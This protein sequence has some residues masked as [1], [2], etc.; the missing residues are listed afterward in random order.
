[1][2]D[3][4]YVSQKRKISR[5]EIETCHASDYLGGSDQEDCFRP[6]RVK[7]YQILSVSVSKQ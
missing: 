4:Y 5:K 1:M 3:Y 6:A 2:G 7:R